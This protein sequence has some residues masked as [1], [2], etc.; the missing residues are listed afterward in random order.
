MTEAL[1]LILD[2]IL[3]D[4]NDINNFISNDCCL[5]KINKSYSK[6]KQY[7]TELKKIN[8]TMNTIMAIQNNIKIIFKN[9]ILKRSNRIKKNNNSSNENI[10]IDNVEQLKYKNIT[11]LDKHD[12]VDYFKIP[13]IEISNSN[14][15]S[16]N[17]SP[18]YFI[19]ETKQY[20][21]KINNN[22]IKGNI[23]NIFSNKDKKT[24]VYKCSKESCKGKFYNKD[25]TYRHKGDIR[26][27]TSYSWNTP[28]NSLKQTNK[29]D[30]YNTRFLGSLSTLSDDI[31]KTNKNEKKLRN[32]QLIHDMLLY[33]IIDKYL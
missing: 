11:N 22:I 17:N 13:V 7:D 1:E 25:C 30:K 23:G 21:I 29:I 33:C 32:K 6:L 12:N 18:I 14:I 15:D 2:E 4:M 31:Y 24:K 16:M 10:S 28:S 26:N 27:F 3:N 8:K 5:D 20:A 9:N 19:K